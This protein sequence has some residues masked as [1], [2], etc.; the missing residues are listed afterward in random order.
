MAEKKNVNVNVDKEKEKKFPCNRPSHKKG[1]I[2]TPSELEL[3]KIRDG[4]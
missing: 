4:D 3:R 1:K 2:P